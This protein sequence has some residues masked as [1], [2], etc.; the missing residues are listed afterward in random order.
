MADVEVRHLSGSFQIPSTGELYT[1][2]WTGPQPQIPLV[3]VHGGGEHSGRYD[4]TVQR[5]IQEGIDV[6]AFDLPGHGRSSGLRGHIGRFDHYVAAT[7]RFVHDVSG[8]YQGKP[9]ALLGHSLGGLIATFFAIRH[10]ETI[11]C[12]VLSSPLWGLQVRVPPWKDLAA[13]LVEPVWPSLTLHRPHIGGQILSHDPEAVARY[14][15][16]PLNHPKA[17][18]RFYVELRRRFREL[19][20]ALPHLR[21]PVL[22]LVAGADRV[23]S[24]ET[25]ARLFGSVGSRDKTLITYEG[26]FH[27]LFNEVGKAR[28][29]QDLIDWL[30]P[31]LLS[32]PS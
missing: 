11:R 26:Y 32:R 20:K 2:Q 19:P 17:S 13:R 14:D 23:A 29:W 8:R 5:L 12:L 9:P 6:H 27:E 28:V 31:R 10:P 21:L 16:D 15:A 1:Q 3:L 7:L 25:T 30:R 18:A 24:S 22:V 4:A